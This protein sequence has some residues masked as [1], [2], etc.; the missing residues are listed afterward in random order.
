MKLTESQETAYLFAARYTHNSKTGG[1]LAIT[2]SLAE[3]WDDMSDRVKEQIEK[4]AK[5]EATANRDDWANFFGWEDEIP[6][7]M[8]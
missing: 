5:H 3:V 7:Y 8:K 4:E 1:A 6:H 2:V